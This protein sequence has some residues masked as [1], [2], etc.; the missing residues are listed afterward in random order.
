MFACTF[1]KAQGKTLKY[2]VMCLHNNP[3]KMALLSHLYTALSRVVEGLCLRVWPAANLFG[4]LDR[5]RK[6]TFSPDIVAL[7]YA[8]D[9]DGIFREDRYKQKWYELNAVVGHPTRPP[10]VRM[11]RPR[12]SLVSYDNHSRWYVPFLRLAFEESIDTNREWVEG[13]Y[14][15]QQ[16]WNVNATTFQ[17]CLEEIR[18]AYQ[19]TGH[20]DV[21]RNYV[22]SVPFGY[23]PQ[24]FQEFLLGDFRLWN[25]V[26]TQQK[27]GA[28]APEYI[29]AFHRIY[30]F[31]IIERQDYFY[32][33]ISS[34]SI[35]V[36]S[37]ITRYI[38]F[39]NETNIADYEREALAVR[40]ANNEANEQYDTLNFSNLFNEGNN[41]S[42]RGRTGRG[43]FESSRGRGRRGDSGRSGAGD[44]RG[45]VVA[46][47]SAHTIIRSRVN[48]R[49]VAAGRRSGRGGSRDGSASSSR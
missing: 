27:I 45:R 19:F 26:H 17:D 47:V 6:F 46:G 38:N 44:G 5:L 29:A 36:Q 11:N 30:I 24:A 13:I 39:V 32:N 3:W 40:V 14:E 41:P 25:D 35:E 2:V 21:L 33:I 15:L 34:V 43:R 16:H 28:L 7:D 23:I 48:S 18:G 42:R 12:P 8:Y 10:E 22:A 1:D 4:D 31:T 20:Y 37:S 49:G 9:E